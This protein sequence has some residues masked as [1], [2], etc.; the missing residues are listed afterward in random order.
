MIARELLTVLGFELDDAN[1]K[2]ADQAFRSLVGLSLNLV[3]AMA[4]V[5]GALLAV[6]K[7]TANAGDQARDAARATGLS[8]EEY[9][10]LGFAAKQAG[11]D[12]GLLGQG[13]RFAQLRAVA[14][15][16]G[17]KD[18][19]NAFAALGI[20]VKGADGQIRPT[21]DLLTEAATRISAMEDPTRRT[22]AATELFGRSGSRLLPLLLEGGEGID[23]LRERARE[24]G[25]VF[26][27]EGADAA[28]AFND[29][30]AELGLTVEG[31]KRRLGVALIPTFQRL[32]QLTTD[33]I[34]RNRQLIDPVLV[35]LGRVVAYV[36]EGMLSFSDAILGNAR[37]LGILIGVIVG[38]LLPGLYSLASAWLAVHA[39][40]IAALAIPIL[41][42]AAF[43][44]LA[45]IIALLI[46]DIYV[47]VTGGESLI[48]H[49]FEA[50]LDAPGSPGDHWIVEVLRWIL[51]GIRDAIDGVSLFF[52]GFFDEALKVG[53]VWEALKIGFSTT[54]DFWWNKL[55]DFVS[56]ALGKFGDLAQGLSK[57]PGI[58][59]LIPGIGGIGGAKDLGDLLGGIISVNSA[60]PGYNQGVAQ[61]PPGFGGGDSGGAGAGSSIS[62]GTTSLKVEVNAQG[63]T[64]PEEVARQTAEALD[65]KLSNHRREL[66]RA[67]GGPGVR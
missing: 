56:R 45:A 18:A 35:T 32:I 37:F 42:G 61:L 25:F 7:S 28:D 34:I 53:G 33:W 20:R 59:L 67:L 50:F 12:V 38:L 1:V 63:A 47:F 36:V 52:Q 55:S 16:Q 9:Q 4:L 58:G 11:V 41:M 2:R 24:L 54:V 57:I 60:T 46:E 13:I 27:Q 64:N 5:T 65:D 17:N 29:S 10:E 23:Q 66:Q 3:G 30:L 43:L 15:I 51:R 21:I 49:M 40:Q 22:A 6:T 48:G 39:A 62:I 8:I 44:A 31:A 14:A 19:A 26:D